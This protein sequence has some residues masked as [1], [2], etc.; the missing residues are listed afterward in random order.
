M[1]ILVTGSK[2]FIGSH[3]KNYFSNK[4]HAVWGCDVIVEYND[5]VY[6]LIDSTNAA[7]EDVFSQG[8]FD[9]CINCA[10]AASVPDS[11][12]HPARDYH[13]NSLNV[14]K[15]LDSIR[16]HQPTCKF[17]NLSSAAVYGNPASL[18]VDESFPVEPL[19]PYGSHKLYSELICKEFYSYFNIKT[20]SLRIFSAYGPGLYKQLF[21]DWYQKITLS[22]NITLYGTGNESRDFIYIEDLVQAIECIVHKAPFNSEVINIGSGKEISIK[23]A[24]EVFRSAIGIDF[25]YTFNNNVRSGDP[26]N[27]RANIDIL[28][29]FGFEQKIDFREGIK[30][31]VEWLRERK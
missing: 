11:F 25:N 5:P 10:G 16:K 2:G 3:V 22:S 14:Y 12:S 19:S 8:A 20:C 30:H 15:V 26:L 7:Y 31:Y 23:E 24:I 6:F 28:L 9:V 1:N 27:W 29:S 13:L 21:W 18:P 4:G 17:V